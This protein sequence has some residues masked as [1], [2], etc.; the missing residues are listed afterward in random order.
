MARTVTIPNFN[1]AAFYYP[2][3]LD[4]LIEFKRANV[5][6][7]TDESD[8][9]PFI[10]LLRAFALVGHLNNTLLDVV[11]N[12]NTL[13]TAALTE[14]VRN[15][16]RLIDYEMSPATPS[17]VELLYELSR[18][19]N[20]GAELVSPNAQA[21]T[22]PAADEVAIPFEALEGLVISRTD[23]L[24]ACFRADA[25]DVF[26]D[27]T[28]A[29]N[30][31][32]G[33][34]PA[35]G[36]AGD[37]LYVGHDSVMW[38]KL[39]LDVQAFQA[40]IAGIWEFFGGQEQDIEPDLVLDFGG[41]Q[42]LFVLTSLLG[43]LNRAGA[44]VRVR[45]NATNAVQDVVS[46]W[47]GTTNVAITGLLG[48]TTP[49]TLASDYQ[50]GSDW[51]ELALAG[52]DFVDNS[53]GFTAD[54][55]LEY[56]VPQNELLNWQKT[57][58]NAVEAFWLRWR[59]ITATG[60]TDPTLGRIRID[61]GK[62]YGIALATQGR[63]V[64]DDPLGSSTGG[65][66]QRFKTSRDYFIA[67]SEVVTVDAEEWI[68]VRDFLNS[69]G[70]DK[71]YKIELGEN[72]RA[73]VVF[74]DGNNGRIPPL[75]VGNIAID[76]R[77]DAND[78]GNVG[79]NTVVVDRTGLS[80]VNSIRNPRQAG[81][82]GEAEGASDASLERAKIAGPASLRAKEVAITP[83]ELVTLTLAFTSS[84]GSK[85]FG[86]AT[87]VEEGFGPKTVELI[88]VGRG[89]TI[90]TQEQLDELSLY[91]NG[92]KYAIPPIP[93]RFVANQT[94]VA[95]AYQPRVID[96]VATVKAPTTVTAQAV[97]NRLN[98]V[99]QPEAVKDDGVTYEWDFGVEVPLSRINHEIFKTNEQIID[100]DITTPPSDL[101]LGPREL[102]KIGTV[103]I[104][105]VQ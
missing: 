57:T 31:G 102:P 27:H 12:E 41:G 21:A 46:V 83:D 18:V 80:F 13:P 39:D 30:N 72:D 49:S 76:Y 5:P 37:K 85:P 86:R 25:L 7:L 63:T 44:L 24:T 104:T 94:V 97:E 53:A 43:P 87:T 3:I 26:T 92:D 29:A 56:T 101:V 78:D 95:T 99:I 77:V 22:R 14:T 19:F 84:S 36:T 74:G 98:Q 54:G 4:S 9:E 68:R 100:V 55:D 8:F 35:L 28:T 59:T 82:W 33:F 61:T 11:A 15:M 58:I 40:N 50:V 47:T 20:P 73:T 66:N 1:F 34:S 51:R 105:V 79:A 81:G 60:A 93:K 103:N 2:Q 71:H 91:F 89:G 67:T 38:N 90:P 6:E 10:Q 96:I 32:A 45:S 16:L 17:N 23:L 65:P 48:Q 70:Q 75:G 64:A 52:I 88:T 42:V 69:T 62:Q